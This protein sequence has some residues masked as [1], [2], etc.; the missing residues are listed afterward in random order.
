MERGC[1][2]HPVTILVGLGF[3]AEIQGAKEAYAWLNEWPPSKRDPTHAIALNACRAALAGEI[4]VETARGTLVAFARR[5]NLL[6]PDAEAIAA[7]SRV[8]RLTTLRPP[9]P[10]P[11][12][13]P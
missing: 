7:A 6:A 11:Q 2:R 5:A 8:V 10:A 3:P 1:F 12:C 9:E 13:D 4:D